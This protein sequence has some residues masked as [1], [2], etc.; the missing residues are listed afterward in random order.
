MS[1][2]PRKFF[3]KSSR[4][5]S[6]PDFRRVFDA[7]N[8]VAD[9][10]LIIYGIRNDLPVSRLGLAV[11]KKAGNAVARNVWKRQI[12]EAFRLQQDVAPAGFD[13]VVL[14]KRGAKPEHHAIQKSLLALMKRL[15][16]SRRNDRKPPRQK[17]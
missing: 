13:I 17:A 9:R 8:S 1:H 16:K 12:R 14:P 11:S 15:E 10:V 7:K 5:L 4:L 6:N 3:P 2:P